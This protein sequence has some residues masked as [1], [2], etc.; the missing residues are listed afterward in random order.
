MNVVNN[1]GVRDGPGALKLGEIIEARA[2][3][4]GGVG[5][6]LQRLIFPMR[7]HELW[8]LRNTFFQLKRSTWDSE[9][10]QFPKKHAKNVSRKTAPTMAEGRF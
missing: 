6:M 7:M 3:G 4:T 2:L 5:N 8:I 10:A 9:T 1:G